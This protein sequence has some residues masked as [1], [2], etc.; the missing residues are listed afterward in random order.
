MFLC[1][2]S[3][4]TLLVFIACPRANVC[5]MWYC[6]SNSVSNTVLHQYD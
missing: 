3:A 6:H 4:L 1:L 2:I 5:K